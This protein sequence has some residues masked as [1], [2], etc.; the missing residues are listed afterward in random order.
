M[1]HVLVG[2]VLLAALTACGKTSVPSTGPSQ[3]PSDKEL[4]DA[5]LSLRLTPGP[6][7]E[8][9]HPVTMQIEV[10]ATRPVELEFSTSQRFEIVIKS[11][12]N[13]IWS[14]STGKVYA[15]V[16]GK[17]TIAAGEGLRY[18]DVWTPTSTGEFAVNAR[19]TAN[20][21][22]DLTVEKTLNVE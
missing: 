11:N 3:S 4:T 19:I 18:G 16:L 10:I 22:K 5:T 20:N 6:P 21:R 9:G 12:G 13:S 15:Q 2:L 17:E 1:K 7:F 14:S 8:T